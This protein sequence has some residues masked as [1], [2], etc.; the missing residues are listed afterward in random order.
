MKGPG[1]LVNRKICIVWPPGSEYQVNTNSD[2]FSKCRASDP[3][4]LSSSSLQRSS[5]TKS[6][7]GWHCSPSNSNTCMDRIVLYA[8]NG[9]K[10]WNRQN[11]SPSKS[12]TPSST[13]NHLKQVPLPGISG[14]CW[15]TFAGSIQRDPSLKR[16]L[17][18]LLSEIQTLELKE[19][20]TGPRK[21]KPCQSGCIHMRGMISTTPLWWKQL[22][23]NHTHTHTPL[24]FSDVSI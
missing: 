24:P 3:G 5:C 11:Q 14:H 20:L 21:R 1:R 4:R 23:F 17:A 2:Y 15:K 22:F 9:I 16:R 19:V 12:T 18:G 8:T 7:F 10:Q 13:E 6:T